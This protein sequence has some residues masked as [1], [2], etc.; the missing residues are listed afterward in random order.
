VYTIPNITAD[1]VSN[2]SCITDIIQ[3]KPDYGTLPP[4]ESQI[5]EGT[6]LLKI[7]PNCQ[8]SH[9]PHVEIQ[10]KS[11]NRLFWIDT[12]QFA[13][14]SDINTRQDNLPSA[15]NLKQNF[16]N[17]FNST[18]IIKYT[19]GDVKTRH[20]VSQHVNLS[21]YNLLGQKVATLVSQKQSAGEY[22]VS[23]PAEN[24][25]SG[26]YYYQLTTDNFRQIRKMILI[27]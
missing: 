11:D 17:P 9:V 2:D 22:S 18:T 12:L 8:L 4:G 26:I 14:V 19:I 5:T 27:K 7:N 3:D 21:I 1:L 16:P 24:L 15:F 13:I 20:A 23:W 10:I 6:Y 25:S